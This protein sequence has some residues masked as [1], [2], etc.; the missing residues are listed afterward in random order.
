M[1]EWKAAT[2]G[3]II[4]LEAGQSLEGIYAGID[5]SKEYAD[6]WC[7]KIEKDGKTTGTFVN[8]IVKELIETNNIMNGQEVRLTFKGLKE[9]EKGTRSYKDYEL[10]FR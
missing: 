9:N 6:S 5:Q 10:L 3:E 8:N 7:F 1:T 4:K 2:H